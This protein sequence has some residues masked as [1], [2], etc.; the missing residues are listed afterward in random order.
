MPNVNCGDIKVLARRADQ[1]WLQGGGPKELQLE[2]PA[3]RVP[4][5]PISQ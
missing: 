2:M 1:N 5:Q 3:I 4:L